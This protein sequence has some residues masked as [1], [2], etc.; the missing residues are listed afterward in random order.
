MSPFAVPVDISLLRK[1]IINLL[2]GNAILLS[3]FAEFSY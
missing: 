2:V 1:P 3:Q